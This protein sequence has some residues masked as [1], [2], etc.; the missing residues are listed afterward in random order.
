MAI[1]DIDFF[2]F[3]MIHLKCAFLGISEPVFIS[4]VSHFTFN[5]VLLFGYS[6][7]KYF[8]CAYPDFNFF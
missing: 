7:D 2:T 6:I 1:D 8:H 4:P 3:C 5:D